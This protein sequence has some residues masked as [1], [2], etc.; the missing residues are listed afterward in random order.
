M[1]CGESL[2]G[3]GLRDLGGLDLLGED[4]GLFQQSRSLLGR[5]LAHLLAD[6]LLLG[7]QVVAGRHRGPAGGVG[8]EERID[9][10]RVF[11]TGSLRRAHQVRIFAQ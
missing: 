5:C 11:A 7:A 6:G 4:L 10:S 1:R 2:F 8:F 3:L 9:E